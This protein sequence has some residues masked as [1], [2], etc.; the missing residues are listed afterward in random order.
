MAISLDLPYTLNFMLGAMTN[1]AKLEADVYDSGIESANL[2]MDIDALIQES[3]LTKKQAEVVRL[4]YY[5]QM[6]QEEVSNVLG[7]SQQAVLDHLNKIKDK[8]TKVIERWEKLDKSKFNN[9]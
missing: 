1:R 5:K 8:L 4:Y 7:I 3:K 6:T 2:I 9:K